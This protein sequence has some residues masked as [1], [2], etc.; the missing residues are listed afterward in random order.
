MT[1]AD[2]PDVAAY[3]ADLGR[4]AELRA[5][6][7]AMRVERLDDGEQLRLEMELE[8]VNARLLAFFVRYG[9]GRRVVP[10]DGGTG[11]TRDLRI[12]DLLDPPVGACHDCLPRRVPATYDAWLLY[13]DPES[14]EPNEGPHSSF[15]LLCE[16]HL[17]AASRLYTISQCRRRP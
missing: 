10:L 2:Q 12:A 14:L 3:N 6:L 8:E 1:D 9:M 7:D 5:A 17:I 15:R 11:E 16:A 13:D 4:Y